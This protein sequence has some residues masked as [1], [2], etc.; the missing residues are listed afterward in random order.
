MNTTFPHDFSFSKFLRLAT[1]AL[2]SCVAMAAFASA[3]VQC[4]ECS[5]CN[6]CL[7]CCNSAPELWVINT[8]HVPKCSNLDRGF[9]CITYQRYDRCRGCFVKESRES[10]LAQEAS[11][12]TMFYLHGNTLKHKG[13]M[14]GFWDLYDKMRCC[15]G[16][17]R[18]VCWSWPAQRVYKMKGLRFREM[19]QK[20]LRIKYVYSE[21]QGY[22]LA[23]LVD[24]MSLTQRVTLSGHSY[25]AISC[26]VALHLMGGGCT[27][28]L[29]LAGAEPVERHNL[30]AAM[31]SGAFD[32]DMLLPGHRYGQAFVAAEKIFS[33][34]NCHDKTLKKWPD[35]SWHGR[36]A[37]GFI[38]MPAR[39]LGEY[40]H[41]LCQMNTYPENKKSHYLSAHLK[42]NRFVS[43]LCCIA[44]GG[45]KPMIAKVNVA[46]ELANAS[47]ETAKEEE[48]LPAIDD[49]AIEAQSAAD[50][51]EVAEEK[52]APSNRVASSKTSRSGSRSSHRRNG[53]FGSRR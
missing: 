14:K 1:V 35:T 3:Q 13:A 24:Q 9:E 30:R 47:K 39:C 45:S 10:F 26:S 34:F 31:I 29:T 41:K 40:R 16:C 25:G 2:L 52:Q 8:R 7:N 48:P 20:N 5:M 23:K 42:N 15:P 33:T 12:P 53:V 6:S 46:T 36:Q 4:D 17:K 11:M 32:Y 19:V 18:L 37:L 28:G 43:A 27:R 22:Y 50:T 21:Y 49:L 38:G 51:E 44:F